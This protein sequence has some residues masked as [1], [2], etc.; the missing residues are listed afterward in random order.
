MPN[1]IELL[2]NT[3]LKLVV[4]SGTDS[5]R[6]SIV[7]DPG[8]LGYTT[9]TKRLYAGDGT[10]AGGVLVGNVFNGSRT[11]VTTSPGTPAIGDLAFDT[12][13]KVLYK[14]NG[15]NPA[16]I[17]SWEVIGGVYTA[18]NRT[19]DISTTS[20]S[21][22][23]LS[24]NNIS[25]DA[26]GRSITL[27]TGRITL[28]STIAVNRIIPTST[29]VAMPSS[30]SFNEVAYKFPSAP[31]SANTFLRTDSA[32]NLS[33]TSI[34]TFLSSASARVTVNKGL[35]ATV[36]GV[37][38]TTFSLITSS[39][40]TIGGV[41]LPTAH[42][43]FNQSGTITRNANVASVTPQDFANT[44]AQIDQIYGQTLESGV[45]PFD[46]P[47]IAG[48][49]IIQLNTP[50]TSMDTAVVDIKIQNGSYY[51]TRNSQF[52]DRSQ[53]LNSYFKWLNTSSI[54]VAFYVPSAN[55]VGTI[56]PPLLTAGYND[57]NTRFSVTVYD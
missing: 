49:Y 56:R 23:S 3:L 47:G 18:R 46:V 43:T 41:F 26:L 20:I 31:L 39:N 57:Q 27:D 22:C 5:D 37:P 30:V 55:M 16:T 13:S 54:M 15:G 35:T 40:V 32:G 12:S 21:V 6:R 14:Y 7:L 42:V 24:A 29:L 44:Q 11:P 36:N 17:G 48:G 33:W 51:Y 1:K 10:T 34:N 8:E 2:Q 19:I 25:S 53:I 50:V 4:R 38:S 9:D 28:S 45:T 52:G